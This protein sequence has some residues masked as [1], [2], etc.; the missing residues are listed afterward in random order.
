M[1][2]CY[3][4]IDITINKKKNRS[5][6]TVAPLAAERC[7]GNTILVWSALA[8]WTSCAEI[9]N[10]LLLLESK[11]VKLTERFFC[12]KQRSDGASIARIKIYIRSWIKNISHLL[13]HYIL[14]QHVHHLHRT[15][16]QSNHRLLQGLSSGLLTELG[17][18]WKEIFYDLLL[19]CKIENLPKKMTFCE[20]LELIF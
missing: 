16:Y 13:L 4:M 10:M 14:H 6:L 20:N 12:E 1:P 18:V 17:S 2:Y 3:R 11:F 8:T 5:D 15:Y 7:G 19:T 9:F